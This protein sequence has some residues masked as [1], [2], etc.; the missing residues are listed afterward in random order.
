MGPGS[1]PWG[2][3]V[4]STHAGEPKIDGGNEPPLG[5]TNETAT[6]RGLRGGGGSTSDE[7]GR[8]TPWGGSPPKPGDTDEEAV[9]A[10]AGT[11]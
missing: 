4:R 11:V 7:S 3:L 10:I 8:T 9:M 1:T 2:V 5:G 6:S